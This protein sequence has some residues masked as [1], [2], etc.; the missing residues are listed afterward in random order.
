MIIEIPDEIKDKLTYAKLEML[1]YSLHRCKT[2]AETARYMGISVRVICDWFKRYPELELYRNKKTIL[3][4]DEGN[5][6]WE[7]YP[8]EE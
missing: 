7:M 5:E 1:K 8:D 4:E 6:K 2:Q 3:C